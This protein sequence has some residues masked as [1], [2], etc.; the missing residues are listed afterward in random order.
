MASI[1]GDEI[2]RTVEKYGYW[3]SNDSTAGERSDGVLIQRIDLQSAGAMKL[4]K[5]AMFDN[6]VRS[7]QAQST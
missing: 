2:L 3:T 1:S 5:A 6:E 4:F 7:A